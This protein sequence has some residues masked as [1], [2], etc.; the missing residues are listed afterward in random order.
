MSGGHWATGDFAEALCL[1]ELQRVEEP[2]DD[3]ALAP[4]DVCVTTNLV[5]S[6]TA[7]L[8]VDEVDAGAGPIVL[9][10]GMDGIACKR[11]LVLGEG[12]GLDVA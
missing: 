2:M 9:A 4:Q 1:P 6:V 11:V 5:A 3:S 10:H 8:I 7:L 12:S